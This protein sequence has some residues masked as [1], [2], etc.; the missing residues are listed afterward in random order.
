MRTNWAELLD[1]DADVATGSLLLVGGI[2]L[3]SLLFSFGILVAVIVYSR[4]LAKRG[5]LT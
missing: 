2:A 1:T 5:V 4:R 3:S